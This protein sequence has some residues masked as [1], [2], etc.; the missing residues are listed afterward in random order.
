MKKKELWSVFYGGFCVKANT[1]LFFSKKKKKKKKTKNM[2][3]YQA[4]KTTK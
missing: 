3:I 4:I 2:L 1:K